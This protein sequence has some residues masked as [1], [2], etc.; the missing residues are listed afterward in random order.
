MQQKEHD[1]EHVLFR[2]LTDPREIFRALDCDTGGW[3]YEVF[4][5]YGLVAPGNLPTLAQGPRKDFRDTDAWIAREAARMD[6]LRPRAAGFCWGDL[7]AELAEEGNACAFY[8]WCLAPSYA[9]AAKVRYTPSIEYGR[10]DRQIVT[11]LGRFLQKHY[12]ERLP[13]AEIREWANRYSAAT[14]ELELKFAATADE[15]E[16]VY[17]EG[18]SS[19]MSKE[20]SNYSS[21]EHPARLWGYC[22]HT[23]VAYVEN[24]AGEITGRALVR[25]DVK[26]PVYIRQYPDMHPRLKAALER[27]GF[28]HDP[29]GLCGLVVPEIESGRGVLMPY[30]DGVGYATRVANGLRLVDCGPIYVQET[31]G[32]CEARESWTCP[33]C[34][35]EHDSDAAERYS[36]YEDETFC[37][38]CS[39]DFVHAL[40]GCGE[41]AVLVKHAVEVGSTWY[42]NDDRTLERYGLTWL[43]DG[44]L[45]FERDV[46]EIE[47]GIRILKDD[48]VETP[49]GTWLRKDEASED[50]F[51]NYCT[52][53]DL[54]LLDEAGT[55][56]VVVLAGAFRISEGK[57]ND[58]D[59]HAAWLAGRLHA[60]DDWVIQNADL[61][62]EQMLA[63]A[64]CDVVRDLIREAVQRRAKQFEAVGQA[65]L[66]LAA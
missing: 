27:A 33:R 1:E 56:G 63:R 28:V 34:G 24:G 2:K 46:V 48:A 23:R 19:C 3:C 9:D 14:K 59:M 29:A 20:G 58:P 21:D 54:W 13:E 32:V 12:K 61:V 26:P 4:S 36:G 66:P 52:A 31:S 64:S 18:P 30:V 42:A 7:A 11:T 65:P 53:D 8:R 62:L 22:K 55:E 50:D 41:E 10:A 6:Y 60:P 35:S 43:D 38:S 25:E 16:R 5:A 15:V 17:T 57:S 45:V 47:D 39:E 44:E 37:D 40:T 51:G 49:W